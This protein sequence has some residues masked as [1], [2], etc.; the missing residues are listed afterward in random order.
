ML[1]GSQL[2]QGTPQVSQELARY[3]S[4]D[5]QKVGAA[6]ARWLSPERMVEVV[7]RAGRA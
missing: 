5:V 7:T 4:L 2:A 3:L 6:A 1:C